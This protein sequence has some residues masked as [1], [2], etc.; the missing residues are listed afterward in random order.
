MGAREGG[1]GEVPMLR[2]GVLEVLGECRSWLGSFLS[3]ESA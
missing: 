2:G 1:E 3:N